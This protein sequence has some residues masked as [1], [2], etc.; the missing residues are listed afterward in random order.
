MLV[1]TPLVT[2]YGEVAWVP[3]PATVVIYATGGAI[4]GA[5]VG[6]VGINV[7]ATVG[8]KSNIV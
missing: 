3:V 1:A 6:D 4:L 7:G 5:T 8:A 2:T